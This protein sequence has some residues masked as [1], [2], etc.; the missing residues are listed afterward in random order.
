MSVPFWNRSSAASGP[1]G[2]DQPAGNGVLETG[3]RFE[4]VDFFAEVDEMIR[5]GLASQK[6]D[7]NWKKFYRITAAGKNVMNADNSLLLANARV[8]CDGK[9]HGL[10][11]SGI[12][13]VTHGLRPSDEGLLLGMKGPL[14]ALSKW[15]ARAAP[16]SSFTRMR[17]WANRPRAT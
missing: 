6:S 2:Q 9:L 3:L 10:G 7:V 5:L 13:A 1:L 16:R 11:C 4:M 17:R 12:V 14:D 8:I 15:P